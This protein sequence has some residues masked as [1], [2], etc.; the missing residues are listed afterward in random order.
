MP[1]VD[2]ERVI[3]DQSALNSV[4]S[5]MARVH[6]VLPVKRQ[7]ITLWVAFAR[8]NDIR[9]MEALTQASGCRIIPVLATADKLAAAIERY[10]KVD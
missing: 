9:A 5:K 6:Q 7:D 3:C 1:F 10:Y 4:P 8:P 2:V